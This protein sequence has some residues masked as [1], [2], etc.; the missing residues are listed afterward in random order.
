MSRHAGIAARWGAAALAASAIGCLRPGSY[1]CEEAAQCRDGGTGACVDGWC[2][3]TDATCASQLR[4]GAYAPADL[5]RACVGAGGSDGSSGGETSAGETADVPPT[6]SCGNDVIDDGEICD[7]GNR[8]AGDGCDPQCAAPGTIL[9]TVTYDGEAH[10]DDRGFGVTIDPDGASFWVAGYTT[11]DPDDGADMLVQRRW[12]E[13]GSL[14]WSHSRDGDG[15]GE[16]MGEDVAIDST[17]RAWLVG[18]LTS[19][20]GRGDVWVE[21]FGRDGTPGTSFT[22]DEQGGEDHGHGIAITTGG[23]LVVAGVVDLGVVDAPDLAAWIRRFDVDG[24]PRSPAIVRNNSTSQDTAL[25][26]TR[27]GEGFVVT[28]NLS[29]PDGIE[30]V[31]TARYDAADA[32]A[33]EQFGTADEVGPYPRGV[34]VSSDGVGG[35]AVAG[36]LSDDIWVQRYA[37]DGTPGANIVEV[38]PN[39]RQDEAGDIE[40]LPDGRFIVAGFLDFGTV[41]FATGDAWVRMYAAD[42]TPEWTDV[43]DGASEETDKALSVGL[44]DKLSAIVVG[45][46]TVPGQSRDVWIR[47]YAL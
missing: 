45:Y 6:A 20:A 12:I 30:E 41:G 34:G 15:H 14:V 25:Q 19:A 10:G 43:F 23:V 46:E 39:D 21:A 33:W 5:A 9:W 3:Y 13:D 18:R 22:H 35:W 24:Q 17:G 32:L 44:T 27:D 38:G 1:A 7:D 31:W 11:V 26:V 37:G 2:A 16:D 29:T 8:I 47:H 40:F 36:V 42:G 28:G 4:Y